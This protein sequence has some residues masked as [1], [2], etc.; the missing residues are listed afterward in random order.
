VSAVNAPLLGAGA[1]RLKSE[2][3][4][5]QLRDGFSET[6]ADGAVLTIFVRHKDVYQRL[7][8]LERVTSSQAEPARH[9]ADTGRPLRVLFSY[10]HGPSRASTPDSI[11]P[12]CAPARTSCSG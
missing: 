4:V 5:T 7:L 12:C 6:A 2:V 1:G 9:A 11:A 3:V 8:G 10:A